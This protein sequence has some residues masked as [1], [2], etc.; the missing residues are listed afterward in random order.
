MKLTE[1]FIANRKIISHGETAGRSSARPHIPV[2]VILP[3]IIKAM[4]SLATKTTAIKDVNSNVRYD[5][6]EP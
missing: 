2:S 6:V 1:L 5:G 4:L 3:N